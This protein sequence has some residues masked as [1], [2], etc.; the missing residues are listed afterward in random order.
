MQQAVVE[1]VG[2]SRLVELLTAEPRDLCY[3]NPR[4]L[5]AAEALAALSCSNLPS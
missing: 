5:I 1:E 3:F 4:F 2:I